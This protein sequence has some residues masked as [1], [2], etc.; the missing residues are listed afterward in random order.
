MINT[1]VIPAA[2]LGTRLFT[3]TKENAKEM[4]PIFSYTPEGVMLVRPL[5]EIIFENLYDKGIRNFV[6]I[7]GRGKESVVDQLTP[8]YDFLDLLKKK[9][10]NEYSG[11]LNKLYKKLEKCSIIWKR[12]SAIRGIGPAT[13]LAE[14]VVKDKP[15]LF[16]SGDLYIPNTGY[17]E[18]MFDIHNKEKP[19]ATIG[20]KKV[21]N[22][23]QYGVANI[24]KTSRNVFQITKAVEKP[25]NPE[26]DYALTG[27][28]VFE[29]EIFN[30]IRKT[31]PGVKG[32]IQLTD[33]IQTMIKEN[34]VVLSSI[35]K[36]KEVCIDIGTPKNYFTALKHSFTYDAY[37]IM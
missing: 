17:L 10:E 14:D 15:F 13:L 34:R 27:V 28:N 33:C 7:V 4:V 31:K 20:L 23:I 2:G 6:I 19:V 30:A 29:P 21:K 32:E 11:I 3:F 35:M 24:K 37:D 5:I 8:H 36:S 1:V 9:G 25:K 26:T 12:Q 18:Q 16:H 22:P